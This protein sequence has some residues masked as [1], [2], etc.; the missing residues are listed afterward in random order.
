MSR[1][2]KTMR[3]T[4]AVARHLEEQK[5]GHG[6]N[7]PGKTAASTKVSWLERMLKQ[8][9]G[10]VSQTAADELLGFNTQRF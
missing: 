8:N 5:H 9:S 3:S 2:Y 4:T 10:K 1:I 7:P 6:Q